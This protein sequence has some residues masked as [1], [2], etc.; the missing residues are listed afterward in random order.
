MNM[1]QCNNSEAKSKTSICSSNISVSSTVGNSRSLGRTSRKHKPARSCGQGRITDILEALS[2]FD[3]NELSDIEVSSSES[4]SDSDDERTSKSSIH[5]KKYGY[6]G[7]RCLSHPPSS[8]SS[9]V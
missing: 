8:S 5:K 2:P 7:P 6:I 4:S 1:S 3:Y 9:S